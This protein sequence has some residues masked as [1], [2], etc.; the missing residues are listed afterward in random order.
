M[1]IFDTNAVNLLPPDGLRADII[2]KLRQSGHHR[3]AVPWMVLEEMAA[4]QARFYPD[5]YRAVLKA[6]AKLS[7]VLPWEPESSL[8]PLDLERL[9]DHWRDAYGEIFEV[10]E[11]SDTAIRRGFQREAM[12]LPPAK[13]VKDRSEGGRDAAIWFSILEFLEQN[14]EEHVWFVTNNSSDFGDGSLFEYPMDEDIRDLEGRLTLLKDFDQ[15]VSRFTTEVSGEEAKAAAAELLESASVRARV[16]HTAMGLSSLTGFVGLGDGGTTEEWSEWLAQP[17]VELLSVTDVT[18]HTI[19]SDVWYTANTHWLLYGPAG[20][21]AGTL[22]GYIACVWP[23]KVLFSTR[24]DETPTL[25]T[26]EDPSPPDTDDEPCM[27]TLQALKQRAADI[28]AGAKRKALTAQNSA[29]R[30]LA[31]QLAP[32]LANLDTAASQLA[33]QA[34]AR[35]AALVNE[36]VQRLARKMAADQLALI[37]NPLHRF[38]QQMAESMPKLDIAADLR[39]PSRREETVDEEVEGSASSDTPEARAAEPDDTPAD[40]EHE[41]E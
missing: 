35:H 30:L 12:A 37:N 32:S 27:R 4:H 21:E 2:R 41:G 39:R 7:E 11:T 20:D 24:D 33:R 9:L 10:I 38:A 15:V 40:D 36:P 28:V 14:P 13:R 25:L 19:E 22:I 17:E 34:A 3:V 18:G 6:V 26:S 1:I 8:E 31:E 5:R 16:A 23:M 29:G